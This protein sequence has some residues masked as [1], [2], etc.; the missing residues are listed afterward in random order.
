MKRKKNLIKITKMITNIFENFEEE[1]KNFDNYVDI[2]EK[3]ETIF[4]SRVANIF[5]N[6]KNT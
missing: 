1:L 4:K 5:D 6:K 3:E 2:L